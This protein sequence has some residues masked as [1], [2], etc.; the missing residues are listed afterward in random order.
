MAATDKIDMEPA[1][2]KAI[3]VLANLIAFDLRI[4][5]EEAWPD[6]LMVDISIDNLQ[7]EDELRNKVCEILGIQVP[8]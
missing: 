8:D 5:S 6:L 4:N 1:I 2:K 3:E 7:I